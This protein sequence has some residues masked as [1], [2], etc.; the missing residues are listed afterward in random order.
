MEHIGI[1]VHK[2]ESQIC[3]LG[4]DGQVVVGRRVRTERDRFAAALG[5]K[6]KARVLIKASTESERVARC[7]EALGHQVIVA[8]PN[9]CGDVCDEE[10]EGENG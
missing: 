9:F 5:G 1:D 4:E 8:D 10:P 3:I 2:K 7:I 6:A